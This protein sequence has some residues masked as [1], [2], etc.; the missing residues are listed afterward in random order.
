MYVE[1]EITGSIATSLS[2]KTLFQLHLDLFQDAVLT[3]TAV[4]PLLLSRGDLF[5]VSRAYLLLAK[6]IVAN[7]AS[8]IAKVPS[9]TGVD[10][11][12]AKR[13]L[14]FME[15]IKHLE[16]ALEGFK[17]VNAHQRVKDTLY[18]MVRYETFVPLK[19]PAVM[20]YFSIYRLGYT[21][22]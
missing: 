19:A 21:M 10:S 16:S 9:M 11:E 6:C 1:L 3:V 2:Q 4:L 20:H 13:G 15:A 8:G 7:S 12:R 14:A 22:P 18:M 17:A 5:E